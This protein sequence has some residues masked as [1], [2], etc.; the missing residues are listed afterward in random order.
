[1]QWLIV[2]DVWIIVAI[3]LG[4]ALLVVLALLLA[5]Q[6]RELLPIETPTPEQREAAAKKLWLLYPA[7]PDEE[8]DTALFLLDESKRTY[9]SWVDSN[10]R[11]ETKAARLLGFLAGGAGLLTVFGS[12]QGEKSHL[13]PG[14]FLYPVYISYG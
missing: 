13:T 12:S 14:P 2:V 1:M 6:R 5:R 3:L 4:A 7:L 9:E 10:S 11:I 8:P